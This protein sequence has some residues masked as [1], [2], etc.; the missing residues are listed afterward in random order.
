MVAA[1]QRPIGDAVA[2]GQEIPDL[3]VSTRVEWVQEC[4]L[5]VLCRQSSGVGRK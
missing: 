1:L 4:I 3:R 5:R 2:G